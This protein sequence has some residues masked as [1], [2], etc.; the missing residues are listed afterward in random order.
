MFF[1]KK[2]AGYAAA[3]FLSFGALNATTPN[4]NIKQDSK[5]KDVTSP[6]NTTPKDD[7]IAHG[8]GGGGGHR[9]G[10]GGEYHG[11]GHDGNCG[12]HGNWNG[13]WNHHG[14]DWGGGWGGGWVDGEVIGDPGWNSN[15]YYST[16]PLPLNPVPATYYYPESSGY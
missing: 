9:G 12:H 7:E 15:Y 13:N 8:G 16:E 3:L 6:K 5:T 11:G 10:G 1:N 4:E 2:A 14:N